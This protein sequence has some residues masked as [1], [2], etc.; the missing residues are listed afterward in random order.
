W[1]AGVAA[2]GCAPPPAPPRPASA[3]PLAPAAAAAA[4]VPAAPASAG[5]EGAEQAFD[6]SR[7]AEAEAAFRRLLDGPEAA[8][9]R[10]GLAR[11][12]LFTGRGAE[13]RTLLEGALALDPADDE[14]VTALAE[15]AWMTGDAARATSLLE[16]I[17]SHPQARRAR[18]LLGEILL[19]LGRRADAEVQLMTL[20]EDFNEDRIGPDD[21]VGL[22]MVGRAAHLL[23]SPHDA[24]DAFNAAER[25][26]RS[27][28]PIL[29]WRAELFLE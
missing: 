17:V 16:G 21:G 24:N 3:A 10:R 25:A 11:T 8:A 2:A 23:R 4:A 5:L 18:L 9:A 14:A 19:D 28:V 6:E 1:T 22:G 13:A 26:S 20:I 29:L 27:N 7:Y 15:I 12:L